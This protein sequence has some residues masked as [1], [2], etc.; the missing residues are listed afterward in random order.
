MHHMKTHHILLYVGLMLCFTHGL[1]AQ[2]IQ[3]GR[4]TEMSSGASPVAGCAIT[5]AGAAPTDSDGNGSF[6]MVFAS[7]FPGDPLLGLSVH[8]KGYVVVNDDKLRSWNISESS[9]LHIVLGKKEI[10]DSLKRKYYDIGMTNSERKFIKAMD[11]LADLKAQQRISEAEYTRKVDSLSAELRNFERKLDTYARKFAKIDRDA[12]DDMES[13][14]L[15]YIDMGD[16]E[17]AIKVYE[18]MELGAKL[19][20]RTTVRDETRQDLDALLPSLVNNY[21]LFKSQN[22]IAGCDS[23]ATLIGKAAVKMDH[24]VILPQW[25]AAK[26]ET[27]K[28]TGAFAQLVAECMSAEDLAIIEQSIAEAG[29]NDASLSERIDKRRRFFQLKENVR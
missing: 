17:E 13:L 27:G 3:K 21:R 23:L 11:Q 16:L 26:G 15:E 28:A 4:I 9:D 14:A 7:S 1:S 10:I 8:K 12:L 19:T 20:S 25:L 29:I 24:K 5:A 6:R 18:S 22:N 2:T